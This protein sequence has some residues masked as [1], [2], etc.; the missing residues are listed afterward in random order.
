MIMK[1]KQS[2]HPDKEMY[3]SRHLFTFDEGIT[4]NSTPNK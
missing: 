2:Q 3:F 1:Q 4:P